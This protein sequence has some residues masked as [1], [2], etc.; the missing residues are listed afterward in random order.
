MKI[1]DRR[2]VLLRLSPAF[3]ADST[4]FLRLRVA[5]GVFC[6]R[7]PAHEAGRV[8]VSSR[9]VAIGEVDTVAEARRLLQGHRVPCF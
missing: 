6:V 4:D 1:A 7:I 2:V 3:E 9:V 5:L 8:C